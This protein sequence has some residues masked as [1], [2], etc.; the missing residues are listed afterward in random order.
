DTTTDEDRDRG[1]R[2]AQERRAIISIARGRQPGARTIE[3][4]A[5]RDDIR[6]RQEGSVVV[7][8]CATGSDPG[9][10]TRGASRAPD[11]RMQ[12]ARRRP[13]QAT[14]E[15]QRIGLPR[16]A[17]D[18]RG[19]AGGPGGVSRHAPALGPAR[20]RRDTAELPR[21]GVPRPGRLLPGRRPFVRP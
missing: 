6:V 15:E 1:I 21:G 2:E 16:S 20:A 5:D 13:E 12:R 18:R 11:E 14:K 7:R 10:G 3:T 19:E 8:P 4:A 9:E 17:A